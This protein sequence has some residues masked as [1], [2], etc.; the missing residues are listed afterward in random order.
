MMLL[1]KAPRT[2]NDIDI[3]WL[4]EGEAF[5][6][7]LYALRDSV[8]VI[9]QRH[10]LSPNWFNYLTQMLLYDQ[11]IIPKGKLWK[12]Y[13]PLAIYI[14]PKEYILALKILAGREKDIDDCAILLPQT[15]IKTRQQAQQLLDQYILPQAQKENT[16]QIEYALDELFGRQ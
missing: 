8:Q 3:F 1:A 6:Q 4:E 10:A 15:K 7:A 11:I 14:P 2:T 13:G 16:E 5:Q 12:R 9:A